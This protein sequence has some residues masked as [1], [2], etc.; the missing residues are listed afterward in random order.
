LR[1][2]VAPVLASWNRSD[3]ADQIKLRDFLDH[4]ETLLAKTRP[5]ASDA[6]LSLSVGLPETKPLISGGNDL[7]NYLFPLVARLGAGRFAA[8]FGHKTHSDHSTLT[9]GAAVGDASIAAREPDMFVRTEVSAQAAWK[10][11]IFDA[12]AT[13]PTSLPADVPVG[14]DICYRVS[15]RRNWSTLWKPS[16]DSLGPVLG[17]SDP[18]RH[19][20]RPDDDCIVYL[21][22]HRE[23]D[24]SLGNSIELSFYWHSTSTVL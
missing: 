22:L 14:L 21:G 12:C 16:I 5:D 19:P 9:V 2:E 17:M 18:G 1:L 11:K 15:A 23:I 7:D 13:V 8:V 24:D 10:Q 4:V 6:A 20:F 3:H